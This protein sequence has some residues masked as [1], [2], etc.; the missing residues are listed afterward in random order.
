MRAGRS[1]SRSS[2]LDLLPLPVL[3]LTSCLCQ[4]ISPVPPVPQQLRHIRWV[5]TGE[6]SA[7]CCAICLVW[8]ICWLN[9]YAIL[10]S[11]FNERRPLKGVT[12]LGAWHS[13]PPVCQG[14]VLTHPP[15]ASGLGEGYVHIMLYVCGLHRGQN[16]G[17]CQTW[18]GPLAVAD[19]GWSPQCGG[20]SL[21]GTS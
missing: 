13:L 15:C 19:L 21:T 16:P 17:L 4:C 11:P 2:Y 20:L 18:T 10:G 12:V 3:F 14:C 6:F 5:R 7:L 1:T 8:Y 9:S